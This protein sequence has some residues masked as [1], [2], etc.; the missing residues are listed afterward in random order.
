MRKEMVDKWGTDLWSVPLR[1]GTGIP[2]EA[3][4]S[5]LL[6]THLNNPLAKSISL[7]LYSTSRNHLLHLL[8]PYR[9]TMNTHLGKSLS[10]HRTQAC[11]VYKLDCGQLFH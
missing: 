4:H 10:D 6:L 7:R 1:E 3:I 8:C 11:F 2:V 5:L 9:C